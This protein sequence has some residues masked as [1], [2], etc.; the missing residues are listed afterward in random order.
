APQDSRPSGHHSRRSKG[1][2]ALEPNRARRQA[3]KPGVQT[4]GLSTTLAPSANRPLGRPVPCRRARERKH[5]R[6]PCTSTTSS[7]A[8]PPPGT[9]HSRST[10]RERRLERAPLLSSGGSW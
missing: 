9:P 8:E 10:R 7:L 3:P 4:G 2:A 5:G 6:A 1:H